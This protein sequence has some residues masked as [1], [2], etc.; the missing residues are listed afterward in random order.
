LLG[1]MENGGWGPKPRENAIDFG[2]SHRRKRGGGKGFESWKLSTNKGRKTP[3]VLEKW[4]PCEQRF[5]GPN[6]R[7]MIRKKRR[8]RKETRA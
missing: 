5:K 3:R 8:K 4:F 2:K 6:R 7:R 1:G